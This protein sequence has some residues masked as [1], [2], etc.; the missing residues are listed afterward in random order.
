MPLACPSRDCAGECVDLTARESE[1]CRAICSSEAPI[2][3]T[4][5]KEWTNLHQ[6]VVS[7]VVRR[8]SIYGLV[9]KTEHGRYSGSSHCLGTTASKNRQS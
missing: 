3:F 9:R 6:E 8:L 5:L 7:R 4:E 2:S 1:V